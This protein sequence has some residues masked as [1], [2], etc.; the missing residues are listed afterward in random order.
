MNDITQVLRVHRKLDKNVFRWMLCQLLQTTIR[1]SSCYAVSAGEIFNEPY[2]CRFLNHHLRP[3]IWLKRSGFF[4]DN[5]PIILQDRPW[6]N[7]GIVMFWD[8]L[9]IQLT[10]VLVTSNFSSLW[11]LSDTF[12]SMTLHPCSD[13]GSPLLQST[14]TSLTPFNGFPTFD[15]ARV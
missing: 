13:L 2:Y 12:D 10:W 4:K 3:A 15:F 8:I 11:T 5:N 7:D 9:R 1:M 14:D 6:C